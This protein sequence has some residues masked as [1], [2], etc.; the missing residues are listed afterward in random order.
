MKTFNPY[1]IWQ[2]APK[3]TSEDIKKDLSKI[4]LLA[5]LAPNSH[6]T[7]PWKFIVEKNAIRILP[8][9]ERP[10]RYS[11][12]ANREL[13]ISLGCAM[14]N[15]IV[16]AAVCNWKSEIEYLPENDFCNT[17]AIIK[18]QK[19]T[20]ASELPELFP[21]I[22][23]RVTNRF[24]Y[25]RRPVDAKILTRLKSFGDLFSVSV[26]FITDRK[27]ME[28]ISSLAFGVGKEVYGDRI[29]KRELSQW[30]S[31]TNST[32]SDGMPLF[33]MEMPTILSGLAPLALKFLPA[34]LLAIREMKL[35][36][37]S[38][39]FLIISSPYD[40][41]EEWLRTGVAFQLI[42]LEATKKGLSLCPWGGFVEH[43]EGNTKIKEITSTN[44]RVLFFARMGYA[45]KNQLHS[46]RRPI[47][48]VL[49]KC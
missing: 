42:S 47:A 9:L 21:Y 25:D 22:S 14:A 2:I 28:K 13:Y 37:T 7:Q 26:S 20:K 4:V 33:D 32:R 24:P 34:N 10:L 3:I 18:F 48:E 39:A 8:D 31:G 11:D 36:S 19:E 1:T 30:V 43:P 38:S 15:I 17:A 46:P 49:A 41:K 44:G 40:N 29:F 35:L 16:A 27:T 23:K 5:T 45:I 12:R 6:N